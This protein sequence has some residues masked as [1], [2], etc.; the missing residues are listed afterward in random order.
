MAGF[1]HSGKVFAV[2]GGS[3]GIGEA[4]VRRLCAEGASVYATFNSQPERAQSIA[5]EIA[6]MGAGNVVFQQVDVSQED[7]A[8]AFIESV[9]QQGGR[10]DGLV[11][12]AGVTKDGLIMRMSA[13]D[14]D[15]VIDTNLKGVFLT[16]RAA[17]RP[18]MSQRA[19]RIVNIGS[20]V[21]LSGNAGQVNYSSAKAG[22][23]G[24]TRSLAKE[25]ASRNVLVNCVAPGFVETDMTAKLTD[26]QKKTYY[27]NIPVKRPA[28]PEEIASVVSF[29]LSEHASYITGQ[30]LNVDGGLAT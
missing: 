17:C 6:A 7:Q 12:N 10:I 4:I 1:D 26:D 28:T 11:N 18:M 13:D 8:K 2:T 3:R 21:G 15:K 16:C 19:G 9:V 20:I 25:L 27:E 30:V 5:S 23:V 22:L 24:L 29:F 14:W